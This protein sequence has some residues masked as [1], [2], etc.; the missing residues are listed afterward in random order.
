MTDEYTLIST[1]GEF[2]ASCEQNF[3]GL[4]KTLEDHIW[5]LKKCASSL[6]DM[7]TCVKRKQRLRKLRGC[8]KKPKGIL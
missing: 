5:D 2:E 7:D 6:E 1:M 3:D 8:G 4:D